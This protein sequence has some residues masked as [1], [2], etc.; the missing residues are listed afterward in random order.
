MS[1][2]ANPSAEF[3]RKLTNEP[4]II[5]QKEVGTRSTGVVRLRCARACLDP[6]N[7]AF[8]LQVFEAGRLEHC[9]GDLGAG[10]FDLPCVPGA[11]AVNPAGVDC[12]YEGEGLFEMTLVVLTP[13][14]CAEVRAHCGSK[15]TDFG[16]LHANAFFDPAVYSLSHRLLAEAEQ[17]SPHGVLYAD[18]VV[19]ALVRA[20]LRRS[21]YLT[22]YPTEPKTLSSR[23]LSRL[24]EYMHAQVADPIELDDLAA[25][26]GMSRFE[27]SR[28]F[29]ATTG[30]SVWQYFLAVRCERAAELIAQHGKVA[31]L[32][33]LAVECGF[34]DQSHLSRHFKQFL[35][36]SPG[37]YRKALSHA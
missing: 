23:T 26:A 11:S 2:P 20:L 13:E 28:R 36:V 5:V 27:L 17:G 32:P 9:A 10:R 19:D 25:V 24:F 8:A 18:H 4:D 1:L 15:G 33:F 29:K 14:V 31:S 35:G 21:G 6:A 30:Q 22:A 37:A 7:R 16:P 3:L 12:L 34:H